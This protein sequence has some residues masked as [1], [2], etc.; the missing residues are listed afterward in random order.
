MAKEIKLLD[1]VALTKEITG[2]NLGTGTVGTVVDCLSKKAFLVDF[3]GDEE[4]EFPIHCLSIDD[5]S[6]DMTY[7]DMGHKE[8]FSTSQ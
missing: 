8:G 2:T 5:L 1:T 4:D 3:I 6:L 7:A